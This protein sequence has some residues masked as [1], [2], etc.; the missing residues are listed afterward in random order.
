MQQFPPI[1]SAPTVDAATLLQLPEK[2]SAA[3][4]TFQ[5]TGGLHACAL[6]DDEAASCC[7]CARMS[8]GTMRST[9]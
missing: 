7:S 9:S 5:R 8:G 6:F 4:E 1:K 2:L 3:Q